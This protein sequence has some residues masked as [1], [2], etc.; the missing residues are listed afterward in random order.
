MIDCHSRKMFLFRLP[1]EKKIV[2]NFYVSKRKH[3]DLTLNYNTMSLNRYYLQSLDL[4][5]PT[6]EHFVS[7][8]VLTYPFG[9]KLKD[10]IL[11]KRLIEL[12]SA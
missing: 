7:P 8:M 10:K 9:H 11:Q 12:V 1:H 3:Q 2:Y 4:F 6:K 5:M